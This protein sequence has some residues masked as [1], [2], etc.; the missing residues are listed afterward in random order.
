MRALGDPQRSAPSIH[1]TGSKGKGSVATMAAAILRSQ[2]RSVGLYTSPH[3]VSYRERMRVDG[4]PIPRDEVARRLVTIERVAARLEST[5]AIERRPTFFEVTTAL[6]FSWFASRRVDALVVEVGIGGRWD[7][8]NLLASRV[9]VITSLELEH[10]DILGP[11]VAA[12]AGEKAGILHP[13]MAG[14]L[15]ELPPE[16]RAVVRAA[17]AEAGVDLW[18]VPSQI[19]VRERRATP[20]GQSFVA[21]W[22]GVPA[23][24]VRI[25]LAGDVQAANAAIALAACDR[26]LRA[27]GGRLDRRA[28]AAALART[29]V[30]GR[31]D[32]LGR[33][34]WV[35]LDVAH[36]PESVRA[37]VRSL[38]ERHPDHDPDRSAVVF[39]CLRGKRHETMLGLLRPFARTAVLVP[40]PSERGLPTETLRPAARREF[41]TVLVAADAPQGLRW[42]R[43]AVPPDGWVLAIG[44]DY[45]VG[46]ILRARRPSA[47]VGEP[48][49][50]DPGRTGPGG[51]R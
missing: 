17:A 40:V 11:T 23:M 45:L 34:P 36:T 3:L 48:D 33:R 6:A 21:S 16:G 51:R 1:I 8:T 43:A 10:T 25:P 42:A 7:A 35:Y 20:R 15:G 22:P 29:D 49:L 13:G 27:E 14:V 18:E 9:G 4:R 5:G 37:A 31:L 26:F 19:G 28:A 47:A 39:G 32:R 50:S 44:S 24:P 38:K 2:G 12:I 46:E 41:P 30:P